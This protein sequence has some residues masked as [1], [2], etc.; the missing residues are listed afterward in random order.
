MRYIVLI[1]LSAFSL[2][3]AF[4]S[5]VSKERALQE[6]QQFF[7]SHGLKSPTMAKAYRAQTIGNKRNSDAA[8]YVFNADND[9]GFVIISGDDQTTPVLGYS[10]KGSFSDEYMP[11]NVRSWLQGYADQIA[12][13]RKNRLS[14]TTNA[15]EAIV[16]KG[17]IAPMMA[18]HWNQDE[19]FNGSCPVVNG[20][21]CVT[22]C[23][24]TAMAQL[25]YFHYQQHPESI[26]KQTTATIPSMWVKAG[27]VRLPSIPAG[28]SLDWADMLSD[29]NYLS[30]HSARQDSA[31][32]NLMLYCGMAVRMVYD[33][34]GSGASTTEVPNALIKYFGF[35]ENATRV[36]RDSFKVSE[37]NDLVYSEL[38]HNRVV[39]YA[40][41][42]SN[43]NGHAFIIHGYEGNGYFDVNWGWGGLFDGAFLLS[44]LT[45][46][47]EGYNYDQNIIIN[48]EPKNN[49]VIPSSINALSTETAYSPAYNLSGQRVGK[50]YKGV[51]IKK[52]RKYVNR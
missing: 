30:P 40:G 7:A 50:S 24:A 42:S 44:S 26:V 23:V 5:P 25:L 13:I 17:S 45:P 22:G 12:Y 27:P 46:D 16:D 29:Y 10:L 39:M 41:Q 32:A 47:T 3:R 6:A 28:T 34:E 31:V 4:A 1:L 36:I 49:S 38:E 8:Y 35:D 33:E 2:T 20:K 19:P 11:D 21:K 18:S 52:G 51:V 9:Q 37:W 43:G 14:L 15:T 48:A